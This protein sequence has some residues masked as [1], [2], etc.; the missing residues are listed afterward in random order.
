MTLRLKLIGGLLLCFF[1]AL[2]TIFYGGLSGQSISDSSKLLRKQTFPALEDARALQKIVA[3]TKQVLQDAMD[4]SDE[5]LLDSAA[6][7]QELFQK[8][9]QEIYAQTGDQALI[10]LSQSFE[11]YVSRASTQVATIISG[12]SI[13]ELFDLGTMRLDREI[14]QYR[15]GKKDAFLENLKIMQN[16]AT[17]FKQTFVVLGSFV[18]VVIGMILLV[19]MNIQ[20]RIGSV[21]LHA[22]RLADGDFDSVIR[23]QVEDELGILESTFEVMRVAL[24]SHIIA[25][26]ELVAERTRELEMSKNQVQEILDNINQGIMTLDFNGRIGDQYSKVAESIFETQDLEGHL[27]SELLNADQEDSR[28]FD[29]WLST[30]LKPQFQANWKDRGL[31]SLNPF[32]IV[33]LPFGADVKYVQFEFEL[34]FTPQGTIGFIMVLVS[35]VTRIKQIEVAHQEQEEEVARLLVYINN[36]ID[37]ISFFLTNSEQAALD[38][39]AMDHL[40]SEPDREMWMREFHTIRGNAGT[41]GFSALAS[42]ASE[43]EDV[44][45]DLGEKSTA[46]FTKCLQNFLDELNKIAVIQ[47]KITSRD[48]TRLEV[49][50]TLFCDIV[51]ESHLSHPD[52]ELMKKK[53]MELPYRRWSSFKMKYTKILEEAADKSSKGEMKLSLIP[54]D[55]LLPES[56]FEI[57]DSSIVHMLRN[58]VDHGIERTSVRDA[59]GKGQ[60]EISLLL[61]KDDSHYHLSITDNGAGLDSQM[62]ADLAVKKS[63]ISLEEASL[64]SEDEKLRLIFRHGFSSRSSV[65]YFSGR[66]VGMDVVKTSIDAINGSIEI[67]NKPGEGVQFVISIPQSKIE[68]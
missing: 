3:E 31:A 45:S 41:F 26:D 40:L 49:D 21:V 10:D 66:G 50:S 23:T 18:I 39:K 68:H 47:K 63:L 59:L 2:V 13:Q 30:I 32:S 42:R 56:L 38:L 12:K 19:V 17:S 55:F 54:E 57:L 22:G 46:D 8:V 1:V 48:E 36:D 58:S 44:L 62:L 25:Q 4:T 64:L 34:V 5:L 16:D 28:V 51:R 29:M 52:W 6:A 11:T 61:Y 15:E 37:A 67:E 60:P 14:R 7:K 33:K 20:K 53:L 9:T 35:D 24:K 27:L 43:V 65:G